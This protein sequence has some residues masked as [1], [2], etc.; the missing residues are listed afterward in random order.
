M[1]KFP[2]V[3]KNNNLYYQIVRM[4]FYTFLVCSDTFKY[5]KVFFVWAWATKFSIFLKSQGCASLVQRLLQS[6]PVL[7]CLFHLCTNLSVLSLHTTGHVKCTMRATKAQLPGTTKEFSQ[8]LLMVVW[9]CCF[10]I[11]IYFLWQSMS[12]FIP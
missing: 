5:L 7:S 2:P 9:C 10:I 4:I 11:I 8:S 1:K 6:L 12:G 3:L